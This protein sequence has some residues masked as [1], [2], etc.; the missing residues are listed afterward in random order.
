MPSIRTVAQRAG[1]STATVSN[2]LNARRSVAPELVS[3][4]RSAVAELG[5][6]TDLG[7]ARLRSRRSTIAGV[8]VPD[9]ANNFFATFVSVL[10]KAARRDGYDLLIV[11]SSDD[12]LQEEAQLRT[13][14]TWRPAGLIILP[15]D[16]SLPARSIAA[17]AGVPLVTA[18]RIPDAPEMDTIGVDNRVVAAEVTCHLIAGGRRRIL[19]CASLLSINNMRERCDGVAAAV[20]DAGAGVE[21]EVIEGGLTAAGCR[22]RLIDRL[23]TPPTPDALFMLNNIVTLGGLE[24][25]A[26][27]GLA[28]PQDVALVGF[29]DAEWM[30]VVSPP[31]TTV[32]QPIEEM[33][34]AAWERLMARVGGDISPPH[35]VRLACTLQIRQSSGPAQLPPERPLVR[36]PALEAAV[37]A[38]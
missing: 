35:G 34:L 27:S 17:A 28:V 26:A 5:Y 36:C 32:R 15:C 14:L 20:R 19:A 22:D 6:I 2:V 38:S 31:L 25:L 4:V 3:R 11:S 29:D 24:A 10:E 12:P 30:R 18:D 8:L 9:I 23:T 13:L 1:V 16:D 21:L 37:R 33:A 7:A